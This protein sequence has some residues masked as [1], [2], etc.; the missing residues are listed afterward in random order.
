MFKYILITMLILWSGPI[1]IHAE[2][3]AQVPEDKDVV[4]DCG[5]KLLKESG[6]IGSEAVKL[7][8]L[9]SRAS[10][11]K[12]VDFLIHMLAIIYVESRFNKLAKSHMEAYGLMQMT[13]GAITDAVRH[14]NLRPVAMDNLFDSHTNVR[15]GT[16]YLGKL[17]KDMNGDWDRTIV[18]YNGGYKAVEVYDRGDNLNTET[19]NY[20]VKVNRALKICTAK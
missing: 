12:D 15:Y 16:C 3:I 17:L 13:E 10:T 5:V 2:Q 9:Y 14:C 4:H 8:S 1:Q 20:L 19:A 18:A 11:S 7:P 6:K